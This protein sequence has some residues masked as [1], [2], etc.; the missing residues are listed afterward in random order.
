VIVELELLEIFNILKY[1]ADGTESL[2]HWSLEFRLYESSD[3]RT[4]DLLLD[5][6][7]NIIIGLYSGAY[8][9]LYRYSYDG[10]QN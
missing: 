9:F 6:K 7:G 4:G 5:G 8:W 10:I 3:R 2:G 1:H